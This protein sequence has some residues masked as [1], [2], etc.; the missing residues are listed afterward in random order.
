MGKWPKPAEGSWTEHYPELG[1]RAH[2]I[3]RFDVTGVLRTR[4]GSDLQASVAERRPRRGSSA[5]GSYFTKEIDAAKTSIIVV[6]G[7]DQQSARSTTSAATAATSWYGTTFPTTKSAA[8]A[9]SSPASTTVGA[10]TSTAR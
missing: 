8:H 2:L 3:S 6:R 1:H 9:G 7:N 5:R 4:A 10:T